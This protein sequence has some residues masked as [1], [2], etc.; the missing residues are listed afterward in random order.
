MAALKSGGQTR[1]DEGRKA[2]VGFCLR[3]RLVAMPFLDSVVDRTVAFASGLMLLVLNAVAISCMV[4]KMCSTLVAIFP[5][6]EDVADTGGVVTGDAVAGSDVMAMKE[7]NVECGKVPS[8]G[9]QLKPAAHV[10][11]ALVASS[12]SGDAR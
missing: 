5:L 8:E 6:G 9:R 1:C 10:V 7:A 2:L 4:G 12:A 11:S 3:V